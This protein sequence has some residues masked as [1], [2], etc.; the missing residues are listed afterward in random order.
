V[1]EV[2]TG[3]RTTANA[4]WWGF[5][6]ADATDCLQAAINSGARKLVIPYLGR[7]WM[8]RPLQLRSQQELYFEPGVVVL[9]KPGEFRGGGDSLFS[10]VG[11]SNLVLRGFG[12]TWRMNKRDY[13]SPPYT[14]AE[15]RM[16]LALRGC[17]NVL[18]EG[19]RI[20][21][22][23]GDGIYIDGGG[24]LGWSED[25]TLR[26]CTAYDN[27]RQGLSVISAVNLLVEQCTFANTWGTAPEAG[28]DLEPDTE[29]NRLVH[30]TIRDCLFEN[31]H[32]NE[33]L[34]YL[35]PL[36]TNSQP[37]SIRFERCL[38][39]M[40]DARLNP[41]EPGPKGGIQG[42]AGIAVGNVRDGGPMGTIEF[43]DCVVEN[44]G[45]ECV[46]VYD[47]SADRARLR[48]QNCSFRNPW[49]AAYPMDGGPRVPILL[50]S[51]EP[52][53]SS[54]LGG[55]DFVDCAVYD[56]TSRPVVRLEEDKEQVGLRD[57]HGSIL[58]TEPG[59]PVA[60]LGFKLQEVDL[61]V[62]AGQKATAV[63]APKTD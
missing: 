26:N 12:A 36:T 43:V 60:R 40:T 30:C 5:H 9:A 45:K 37:V 47:K 28:I 19:L 41:P 24:A 57:V 46:R 38:V 53:N 54:R 6:A 42:V 51:R 48:F 17:R 8:V 32:G 39:R 25:I 49:I 11:Q 58:V 16:G 52:A 10:A 20:E 34:V 55:I 62:R 2:A 7:P 33:V 59:T 29:N 63:P 1:L 21:G 18:V 15:W 31:N 13:Q 56:V 14:K 3:H 44:T 22:S 27:H 61:V 35:K 23:G 4:A 50:H